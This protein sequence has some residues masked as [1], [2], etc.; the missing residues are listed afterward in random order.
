M[1]R[2]VALSVTAFLL[3]A[4]SPEAPGGGEAAPPAR[5]RARARSAAGR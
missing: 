1:H 3:T 2:I 5:R 4:C